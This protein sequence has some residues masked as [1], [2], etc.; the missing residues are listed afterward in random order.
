MQELSPITKSCRHAIARIALGFFIFFSASILGQ[1]GLIRLVRS[2][3]PQYEETA[4]FSWMASL[5]PMYLLGAPLLWI[6]VRNLPTT[7]TPRRRI[8][9]RDLL[10]LFTISFAL[11]Y[12]ANFIGVGV[13]LL[14]EAFFGTSSQAG[15]T[16]LITSSSLFITIPIAVILG[17]VVEE[18]IFRGILL[19]RLMPF[20]ER[21]AVVTS[22]LL[23]GLFHCNLVQLP[24][25]FAVGLVFG[26][27][28]ARTGRLIYSI[29]L[30]ILLNFSGTVPATLMMPILER[31]ESLEPGAETTAEL[32]PLL[33][34]LLLLLLYLGA[35]MLLVGLGVFFLIL[36]RKSLIP[37]PGA[38]PIPKG[39]WR[40]IATS[41][42]VLLYALAL[43]VMFML[44]YL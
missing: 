10:I 40:Y 21:F 32:M 26:L 4:L 28:A 15:A 8:R 13:N 2:Y 11:M 24:Y 6:A 5:L 22:A 43:V 35:V 14:T 23:F 30:H 18:I 9:L 12:L 29:I 36:H 37:K 44:S 34:A 25:A 7:A 20:G 16:E 19:P 1:L 39:A 31:F 42:A 41:P 27:V 33:G 17:P 38:I 3:L